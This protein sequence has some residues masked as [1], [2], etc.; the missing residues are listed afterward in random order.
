MDLAGPSRVTV[1]E[2]KLT[3]I[4]EYH[5]AMTERGGRLR[6]PNDR[7]PRIFALDKASI[8]WDYLRAANIDAGRVGRP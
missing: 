3:T 4:V 2:N 1:P 5:K 7:R 6:S 8:N